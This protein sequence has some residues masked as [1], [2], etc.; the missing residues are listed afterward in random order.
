MEPYVSKGST[1]LWFILSKPH[2]VKRPFDSYT[3]NAQQGDTVSL[4]MTDIDI[5][6]MRPGVIR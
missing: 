2:E 1:T 4:T 3:F 6:S 5:T